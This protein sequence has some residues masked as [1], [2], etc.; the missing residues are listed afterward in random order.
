MNS[1]VVRPHNVNRTHC[2]ALSKETIPKFLQHVLHAPDYYD[3]RPT[4]EGTMTM[5]RNSF[6]IDHQLGRA[7][8][9]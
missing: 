5:Q 9:A 4:G 7:H 6:H 1:W 2:F 8:G 3:L